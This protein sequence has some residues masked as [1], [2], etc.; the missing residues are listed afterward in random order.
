MCF[1]FGKREDPRDVIDAVEL[2]ASERHRPGPVVAG[3]GAE[4]AAACASPARS[5]SLMTLLKLSPRWLRIRESSTATSS[6]IVMVVRIA[7]FHR[8]ID[9]LMSNHEFFGNRVGGLA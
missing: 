9:V 6:S 5:V 1:P 7:S 3:A 4:D 2:A 8:C